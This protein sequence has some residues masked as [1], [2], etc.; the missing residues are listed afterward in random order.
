MLRSDSVGIL[1]GSI[2]SELVAPELDDSADTGV[3]LDSALRG[4]CSAAPPLPLLALELAFGRR[5]LRLRFFLLTLIAISVGAPSSCGTGSSSR[6]TSSTSSTSV[7]PDRG[8]LE[9]DS[10]ATPHS[11][12]RWSDEMWFSHSVQRAGSDASRCMTCSVTSQPRSRIERKAVHYVVGQSVVTARK[13]S[14][15]DVRA[16]VPTTAGTRW[17]RARP[18]CTRD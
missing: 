12:L 8:R 2:C 16:S 7:L 9:I 3:L 13:A 5:T 17:R 15:S 1:S 6:S 10:T 4:L 18:T 11:T 14:Q